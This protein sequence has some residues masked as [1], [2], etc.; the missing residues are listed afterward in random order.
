[1]IVCDWNFGRGKIQ[2]N[3][4]YLKEAGLGESFQP[5]S[6]FREYFGFVPN[7][8]LA[9]TL[10]PRVIA[11]EAELARAIL[12]ERRCL[13]Q[14]LKERMLLALAAGRGST[15]FIGLGSQV[16]S[17]LGASDSKTDL[18]SQETLL[19][20][21][22]VK[23]GTRS[24]SISR[25]DVERIAA[26]RWTNESMLEAVLLAGWGNF[27]CTLSVGLGAEPDFAAAPHV[28]T[29]TSLDIV[30]A[31]RE[32]FGPYLSAKEMP[33]DFA[34]YAF[35]RDNF[36]LVPNVFQLQGLSPAT[37]AAEVEAMRLIL[38]TDDVLKRK[39]KERILLAVSASNQN[40]YCVAVYAEILTLS[41]V[42]S[43]ESYQ[44]A[45]DHRQAGLSELDRALLDFA[46]KLSARPEEFSREDVES[47][48]RHGLS[49]EQILEAVAV[50]ALT[51]FLNTVQQG[52][53]AVPD[54]APRR[55]FRLKIGNK[56]NLSSPDSR[57]KPEEEPP[58]PD[59]ELVQ[60]A[61]AGNLQAFEVL[62]EHHGKRVYRTL[63]GLL[64]S[65]EE[66]R[67]AMQDTF[68][69]AFQHLAGFQGRSKFST[70]L[71]R[72]ASN[73]GLQRLRERRPM[74]SLDD[75]G[76]EG[77]EGFRPRQV[78]A[79]TDD[80]EQLYSQSEMRSLVENCLKKLPAKYRVV[81]LLR[82]FEQLSADDAAAAL[83]LGVPA[84][85][86]RLLR[87]RLMLRE[88]LAPYFA[89]SPTGVGA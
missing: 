88:A 21:F 10:L 67:D 16:L 65:P 52:T 54:F 3:V 60:K 55:S 40:T 70:W 33:S 28:A 87:G 57:P 22:T 47:L 51:Q 58:D 74:E 17:L 86:S 45:A 15:Y 9:Q 26:G 85:K 61:Q 5:F 30:S 39:Q 48:R 73:A 27:L 56:A 66:A 7:V 1:V 36:G 34:P 49:D 71:L 11:A 63:V 77:E 68:L 20:D 69:K 41:G 62:V 18:S 38:L 29:T 64:G 31:E 25:D 2:V 19:V 14:I 80:P 8:F 32:N 82:D 76:P 4:G 13:P 79:W 35:L 53:G 42:A 46:V 59:A 81:V 83:G 84:L 75:D 6:V 50:T 72:I 12:L 37:V 78:R 43:E 89:K 23:L 44:I 24:S